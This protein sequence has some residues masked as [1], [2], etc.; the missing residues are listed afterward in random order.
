[1]CGDL[2]AIRNLA[3][4]LIDCVRALKSIEYF[5]KEVDIYIIFYFLFIFHD[6]SITHCA[7]PTHIPFRNE[8]FAEGDQMW[9]FVHC[10]KGLG[11]LQP[12]CTSN[13]GMY[14]HKK[15]NNND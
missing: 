6:F 1:M 10:T 14:Q 15:L 13:Q 11:F 4:L 9:V 2:F 3:G 5:F 8:V 7:P 12:F